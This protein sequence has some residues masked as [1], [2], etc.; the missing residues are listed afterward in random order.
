MMLDFNNINKNMKNNLIKFAGVV[1]GS[2]SLTQTVQAIGTTGSIG[3]T[4][5]ATYDTTSVGTATEVVNWV[6]PVVNGTSGAFTGV[7]NGTAVAFTAPWFFNTASTIN[8]F[9]VVGGFSFQLLTSATIAQGISGGVGY[10]I[11]SGRGIV[12]GNGY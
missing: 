6:L 11:V 1:A 12:S 9:W 3:F 7:A 4:G 10:V 5:R 2:M 8:N